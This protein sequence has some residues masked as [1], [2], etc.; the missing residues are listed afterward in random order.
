MLPPTSALKAWNLLGIPARGGE[1]LLRVSLTNNAVDNGL[2]TSDDQTALSLVNSTYSISTLE[3]SFG[4][5]AGPPHAA[6]TL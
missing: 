1:F 2:G 5:N 3:V 6:E 4:L